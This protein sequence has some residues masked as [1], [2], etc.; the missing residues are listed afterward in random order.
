ML[1]LELKS[2]HQVQHLFFLLKLPGMDMEM[3]KEYQNLMKIVG[4]ENRAGQ[5]GNFALAAKKYQ[6]QIESINRIIDMLNARG[7]LQKDV[8]KIKIS[9]L[10]PTKISFDK[11]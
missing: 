3:E 8:L 9:K 11:L 1:N 7:I 2:F 4:A 6:K 5:T 10:K